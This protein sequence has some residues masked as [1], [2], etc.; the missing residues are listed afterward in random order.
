MRPPAVAERPPTHL[1]QKWVSVQRN[2]VRAWE[3][4]GDTLRQRPGPQPKSITVGTSPTIARSMSIITPN[5]DSR[6]GR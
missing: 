4:V 6:S 5:R 3:P 1:K 2:Y